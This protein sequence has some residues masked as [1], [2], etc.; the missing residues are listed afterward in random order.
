LNNLEII[1]IKKVVKRLIKEGKFLNSQL[2]IAEKEYHEFGGYEDCGESYRESVIELKA[3]IEVVTELKISYEKYLKKL[4]YQQIENKGGI[5]DIIE[6]S[7]IPL[8]N[9]IKYKLDH[10]YDY[11][12]NDND[13]DNE[14]NKKPEIKILDCC[15]KIENH[16][17]EHMGVEN[18]L[19]C[20]KCYKLISIVK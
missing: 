9:D 18:H 4:K 12:D 16:I 6:T 10:I 3:K 1:I 15:D 7:G 19:Y 11:N 20:K 14:E 17:I 13:N 5:N 8:A 2:E